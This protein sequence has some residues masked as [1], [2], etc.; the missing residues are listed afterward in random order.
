M[1]YLTDGAQ[2][3]LEAADRN[4]PEVILHE[5]TVCKEKL[6]AKSVAQ[7]SEIVFCLNCIVEF[8]HFD[9]LKNQCGLEDSEI[10]EITKTMSPV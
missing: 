2:D 9:Y 3:A 4:P 10:Y 5:C 6:D 7:I 8:K 1:C